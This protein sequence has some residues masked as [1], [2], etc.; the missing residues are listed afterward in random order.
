MK[1]IKLSL[2][3]F[4]LITISLILGVI[5]NQS[6]SQPT[7]SI[8]PQP[9]THAPLKVKIPKDYHRAKWHPIHFPP[10]INYAKDSDCLKCHREIKDRKVLKMSPAGVKPEEVSAWYQHLDVYQGPQ[11][12]FHRRHLYDGL[13]KKVLNF[14]CTTCHR[15]HNPREETPVP[16]TNDSAKYTM[17]K[18]VHPY[19][20]LM[21]HGQFPDPK[22]MGLP[23]HWY[24]SGKNMKYNCLTCHSAI[25]TDRHK[26]Y[27]LKRDAIEK[28]AKEKKDLCFGCHGGRAWYRIPFPYKRY[29]ELKK[30]YKTDEPTV[31]IPYLLKEVIHSKTYSSQVRR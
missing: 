28:L 30:K 10:M 17:R 14:K 26:S 18:A 13:A 31:L 16:P 11:D 8:G 24:E 19:V 27:F 25:R 1:K 21:C 4:F 7:G 9:P 23:G 29:S 22:M 12:T 6:L 5:I 15:G 2:K 3:E 20:C